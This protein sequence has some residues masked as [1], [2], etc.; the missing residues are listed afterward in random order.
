MVDVD[1]ERIG[2]LAIFQAAVSE[3]ENLRFTFRQRRHYGPHLSTLVAALDELGRIRRVRCEREVQAEMG[4]FAI[5]P[6]ATRS[7][8]VER[9]MRCR[10][11]E[12]LRLERQTA[13]A[14]QFG[15]HFLRDVARLVGTD[16]ARRD[17]DDPVVV[18]FDE[19]FPAG[20]AALGRRWFGQHALSLPQI[21][22]KHRRSSFYDGRHQIAMTAAHVWPEERGFM[23]R[24]VPYIALVVLAACAHEGAVVPQA[25]ALTSGTAHR[26]A[27]TF[28]PIQHIVIIV[29]ENRTVDNLFNGLPGADTVTTGP[30]STGQTV[31]LHPVDLAA[32]YDLSH[33]HA[34]FTTEYN[35]GNMNG[36]DREATFC[37]P[38]AAT[39]P[40]DAAYGYVPQTQVQPYW[41]MAQSY[42]FADRMFQTNA[43]ASFS[44]HQY[45]ISGTAATDSTGRLFAMDNPNGVNF[46]FT[47]GCDSKAGALVRLINPITNDQSQRT[48]PCFDH[49]VLMDLLDARGVTWRYYQYK[50]GP[51][52][53]NAPDA[54]RHVRYGPD[55]AYVV[56]TSSQVINDI[57]ANNLAGVTWVTPTATQSDHAY[58]TDG[59]GPAWVASVVNAVGN[60]PYWAN[61]AIFVTWDDWGGW[62]DH[63]LP[64]QFNYYE[65]GF[66]VPLIAISPY[67]KSGYVS[68]VQHEFGSLLRFTE[69]TFGLPSLGYTDARADDLSDMFD[70]SQTPLPFVTIHARP[71]RASTIPDLRDPDDDR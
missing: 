67:A 39:P 23:N 38:C 9:S 44:A 50:S 26:A 47:G 24:L 33:K 64:Q 5:Q 70:Y 54:I 6:P 43:G 62:Y 20:F 36:F 59:S 48:F 71:V 57:N 17:C 37:K 68:H 49:A 45:L 4:P 58:L 42:A 1:T 15:K 29:Q 19:Q 69:E 16:D 25:S 27:G 3:R 30:T 10:Q 13:A 21:L 31:A 12:L 32:P 34:A 41:T 56:N 60:S 18:P 8:R 61:T 46:G 52:L 53:W 55:F 63:V 7:Q 22:E 65:L 66:R 2:D 11:I 14:G 51:G 35:A 28:S 40:P